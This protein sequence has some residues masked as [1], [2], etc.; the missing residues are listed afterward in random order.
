MIRNGYV[1]MM[2]LVTCDSGY[3]T[4]LVERWYTSTNTFLLPM[5]ECTITLEDIYRI[6]RIL[7]EGEPMIGLGVDIGQ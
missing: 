7:I 6:F 2:D 3:L 1:K 4:A 5:D